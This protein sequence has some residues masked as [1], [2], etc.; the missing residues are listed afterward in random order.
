MFAKKILKTKA[1]KNAKEL[2]E[3]KESTKRRPNKKLP[4]TY[5]SSSLEIENEGTFLNG[6][7]IEAQKETSS[8]ICGGLTMIGRP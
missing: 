2:L 6:D 8:V 1:K 4:V 5:N 3:D 7:D